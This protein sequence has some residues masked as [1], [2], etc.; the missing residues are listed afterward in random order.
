[1]TL[2]YFINVWQICFFHTAFATIFHV[3]QVRKLMLKHDGHGYL[4]VWQMATHS[5][6]KN[7]TKPG[8]LDFLQCGRCVKI[9]IVRT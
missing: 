1:M 7:F 2:H 8:C 4:Y 6:N 3:H 5:A 9:A